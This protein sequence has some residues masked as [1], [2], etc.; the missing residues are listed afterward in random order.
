VPASGAIDFQGKVVT[1]LGGLASPSG[2]LALAELVERGG[3]VRR[4]LARNT[5]I[6]VV[7]RAAYKQL[8][9][10]RL[11][12]K[13]R[14]ADGLGA[15]CLSETML[16]DAL[17]L[18]PARPAATAVLSLEQLPAKVGL[19]LEV[20]R[21][22]VLFDL[23]QPQPEGFSFRDLVAARE[24]ARL[25]AEGVALA[26]IVETVERAAVKGDRDDQPLAR[27][28]L[29]SDESGRIA[30]RIGDLL[31]ELDGQLRLPLCEGDNP[32]IDELFEAAEDAE[33][34]GDLEAAAVLY[35]RCVCLDRRDPIAAFNLANVLRELG[36]LPAAKFH[37]RLAVAIDPTFADAWYNLALIMD[38][39]GEKSAAQ[40][41]FERAIAADPDYADPLYNLAQLH[42]EAGAF[43]EAAR[44]W[45]RYLALDPDSEW[46]RRARYGLALCRRHGP[47]R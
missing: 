37:L 27:L 4:D 14:R 44:L 40:E 20:L 22:L 23:I 11:L 43:E 26:D 10:G 19:G 29:V 2:R 35:Q 30:T 39:E 28:K 12:R 31:A 41:G 8:K 15:A 46:G 6:L 9:D 34:A 38:A 24:V 7:G 42:Y 17:D 16:L 18:L 47:G 45:R 25:L 3:I 33:Q 13:L 36:E 32:S 21:L 1:I 5:A